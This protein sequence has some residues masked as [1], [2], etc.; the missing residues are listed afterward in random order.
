MKDLFELKREFLEYCELD[1]GQS[2]LT[3]GGYDRYLDRFLNWLKTYQKGV[4]SKEQGALDT[5]DSQP[6]T[7]N[8]IDQEAVRKYRLYINRLQN[9]KGK[10]KC[11]S[12]PKLRLFGGI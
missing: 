6:L 8:L 3:I 5:S 7:P 4:K 10:L 9:K 11:R 12:Y 2:S 1:K